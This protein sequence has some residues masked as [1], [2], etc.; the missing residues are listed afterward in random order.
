MTTRKTMLA[1]ILMG[2]LSATAVPVF[3]DSGTPNQ[4]ADP[5]GNGAK[6]ESGNGSNGSVGDNPDASVNSAKDDICFRRSAAGNE[7]KIVCPMDPAQNSPATA[8][9]S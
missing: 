6:S 1:L 9:K 8:P 2:V 4:N 5:S 7:T 3:A